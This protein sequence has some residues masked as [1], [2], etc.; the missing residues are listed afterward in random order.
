MLGGIEL[1][2]CKKRN[3]RVRYHIRVKFMSDGLKGL[4]IMGLRGLEQTIEKVQGLRSRWVT[5]H[6]LSRSTHGA[7]SRLAH[8]INTK[9]HPDPPPDP[10]KDPSKAPPKTPRGAA[11]H[12]VEEVVAS[13]GGNAHVEEDALEDGSGKELPRHTAAQRRETCKSRLYVRAHGC[14][15]SY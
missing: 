10:S 8:A 3:G 9:H 5:H 1:V 2:L 14:R 7:Y 4:G 12:S 15:C 13:Q 11:G 6:R